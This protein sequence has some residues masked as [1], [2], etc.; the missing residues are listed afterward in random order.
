MNVLVIS[1]VD[2]NNSNVI[3]VI[4]SMDKLNAILRGYF[5]EHEIIEQKDV[6]Q[7]TS[8]KV[9]AEGLSGKI[10]TT[11]LWIEPFKINEV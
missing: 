6:D 9:N 4:D 7:F 2:Y 5:G 1:E 11:D 3:G 8:V 10:E